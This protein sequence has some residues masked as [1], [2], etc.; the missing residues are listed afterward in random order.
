MTHEQ[1]ERYH[2]GQHRQWLADQ[3]YFYGTVSDAEV[4]RTTVPEPEATEK[5]TDTHERQ[6]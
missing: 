4:S 5:E 3:Q 6:S 1:E 2:A